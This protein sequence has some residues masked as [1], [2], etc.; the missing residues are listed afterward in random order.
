[1]S[2]SSPLPDPSPAASAVAT[3]LTDTGARQVALVGPGPD[4][5]EGALRDR[6]ITMTS[7]N[8]TSAD[9][10]G[11]DAIVVNLGR[12]APGELRTVLSGVDGS[13]VVAVAPNLN[14]AT[15]T[16]SLL[17]GSWLDHELAGQ[18]FFTEE[19]VRAE[20]EQAGFLIDTLATA[21]NESDQA[22]RAFVLRAVPHAAAA[23]VATARRRVVEVTT[24]RSR[25]VE[26]IAQLNAANA[27]H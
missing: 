3:A 24:E 8:L 19:T 16:A 26:E 11:P 23:Q 27:Q 14:H 20:I 7:V 9:E 21:D 2:P 4:E 15:V 5:F 13:L 17:D 18:R 22:P 25:L 1:M 10:T 6:G 12:L